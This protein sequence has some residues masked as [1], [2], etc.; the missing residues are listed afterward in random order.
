MIICESP[1]V[2]FIHIPRTG[3]TSIRSMFDFPLVGH[4]CFA[5]VLKSKM[6]DEA[7]NSYF[8]FTVVRNPW[9]RAVSTYFY[10]K[11]IP[12][13]TVLLPDESFHDWM[14]RTYT[15]NTSYAAGD[16]Y[17]KWFRDAGGNIIVD[18]ICRYENYANDIREIADNFALIG[19]SDPL[20]H[21][22]KH[23][24]EHYSTYHDDDTKDVVA[25]LYAKDIEFFGYEFETA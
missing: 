20:P 14:L 6:T 17:S 2:I 22:N 1:K 3:G 11:N 25:K 15:R 18:K 24:R 10:L 7:W 16:F 13:G 5:S 12:N 23:E 8:K 21:F 9:D 4:Q 19:P